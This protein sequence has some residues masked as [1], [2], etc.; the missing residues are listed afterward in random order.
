MIPRLVEEQWPTRENNNKSF[1]KT[2][3][4]LSNRHTRLRDDR[5]PGTQHVQGRQHPDGAV[6]EI[7]IIIRHLTFSF[8]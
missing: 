8:H 5:S 7:H 6:T 1:E 4:P 3:V 2:I